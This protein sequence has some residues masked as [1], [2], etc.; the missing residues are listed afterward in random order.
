MVIVVLIIAIV[1]VIE[2]MV[3][4]LQALDPSAAEFLGS[5]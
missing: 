2:I 3:I 1:T 5:A 4:V